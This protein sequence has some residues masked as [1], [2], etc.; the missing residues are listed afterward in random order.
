MIFN[1]SLK[2]LVTDHAEAIGFIAIVIAY[3]AYSQYQ[4]TLKYEVFD[5]PRKSDF[6]YVDYLA[7]DK[8]SDRRFR[9][10]PLKV[11]SVEPNGIRFKVGNIAHTTPVSPREHAK[12]DRAVLL[13]NYFKQHELFLSFT[14]IEHLIS[15]NAIYDARRPENIYIDGWIVLHKHEMYIDG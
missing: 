14:D 2:K 13:R 12:L 1:I 15:S 10:I 5:N 3:F 9:Y 8:S 11:L 4:Q 6:Y 7:I